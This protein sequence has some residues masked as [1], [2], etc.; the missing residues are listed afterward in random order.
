M[1]QCVC[2]NQCRKRLELLACSRRPSIWRVL[3]KLELLAVLDGNMPTISLNGKELR[4][5]CR[6]LFGLSSK[7][8]PLHSML[9]AIVIQMTLMMYNDFIKLRYE[10][11]L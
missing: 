4:M 3:D 11:H 9:K 6:G 7:L 2:L 8:P 5:Q 10:S 1:V